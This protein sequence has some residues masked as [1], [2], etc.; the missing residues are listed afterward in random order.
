MAS[1]A[2]KGSYVYRR[3]VV[4]YDGTDQGRDALALAAALRAADGV[5]TAVC[6]YPETGH[7]RGEQLEPAMAE[8]A[9]EAL[10]P[11]HE[12]VGADWLELRPAPGH[13]PAHGLHRLAEREQADL[14]VV[15]SSHRGE[16]GRALAGSVGQR[17]LNG[18]HCP[19]AVASKGFRDDAGEPRVLGVA[20]DGSDESAAALREA[21][22]LASELKAGLKV[23]TVVPPLESFAS[24]YPPQPVDDQIK[25]DR[26][27]E[28]QHMLE[29]AVEP[30][31]GELRPAAVLV[32]GRPADA[33]I[34]QAGAGIGLLLMGSRSYGPLRR[35]M[36]GSTAI[37]VMSR[38]PCPVIVVPRGA[39]T[40]GT[41]PAGGAT[42]PS[43]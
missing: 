34:N 31:S 25:A 7:G 12:E 29:R 14:V 41:P 37:D 5:V 42:A 15:G 23:I 30:L 35:V 8:S 38:S 27:T 17:L 19:V 24:L 3:I 20:Y 43:G 22:A 26:R 9:R 32:D 16:A 40:A 39:A 18:S 10:A 13:S 33:I 11:A 2:T 4:G 1:T 21:A 28:F 36:L 6:V